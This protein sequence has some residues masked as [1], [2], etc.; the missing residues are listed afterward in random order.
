MLREMNALLRYLYFSLLNNIMN[1]SLHKQ[2]Y[3]RCK[4]ILHKTISFIENQH[5]FQKAIVLE[6]WFASFWFSDVIGYRNRT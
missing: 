5:L 1:K 3:K 6:F 4:S 2:C